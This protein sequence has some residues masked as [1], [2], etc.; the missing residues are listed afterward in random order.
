[1]ESPE[2]MAKGPKQLRKLEAKI[3]KKYKKLENRASANFENAKIN[4]MF[5]GRKNKRKATNAGMKF[6]N[7]FK[8]TNREKSRQEMLDKHKISIGS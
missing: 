4:A 1:M 5:G 3:A 6:S 7:L 8:Q 2:I